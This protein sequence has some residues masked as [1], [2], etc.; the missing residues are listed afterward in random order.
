MFSIVNDYKIAG[1]SPFLSALLP[2][3]LPASLVA[4][5]RRLIVI[6]YREAI[7]TQTRFHFVFVRP[8]CL[9]VYRLDALRPA[10]LVEKRGE[11]TE[12]TIR[13][14]NGF[15]LS[16]HRLILDEQGNR[17]GRVLIEVFLC[18][19]IERTVDIDLSLCLPRRHLLIDGAV[20]ELLAELGGNLARFD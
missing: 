17:R 12:I 6:S 3:P 16:R 18:I 20:R 14:L 2:V 19:R 7:K 4:P 15:D 13:Q 11:N 10:S 5:S 1:I 8:I 9:L